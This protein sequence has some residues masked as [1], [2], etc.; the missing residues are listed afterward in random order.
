MKKTSKFITTALMLTV[1]LVILAL[2]VQEPSGAQTAPTIDI[3]SPADGSTVSGLV[4]LSADVNDSS[5]GVDR[6]YFRF[7]EDPYNEDWA[8]EDIGVKASYAVDWVSS[9]YQ[10]S[11]TAPVTG[12]LQAVALDNG[13]WVD[14]DEISLT[15]DNQRQFTIDSIE[16]TP[17]RAPYG[18]YWDTYKIDVTFTKM[19]PG[20]EIKGFGASVDIIGQ[21]PFL[22]DDFEFTPASAETPAKATVFMYL[23]EAANDTGEHTLYLRYYEGLP[24]QPSGWDSYSAFVS[25]GFTASPFVE[26]QAP[27]VNFTSPESE[28]VYTN[29]PVKFIAEATD[30]DDD[31]LYVDFYV[32][33]WAPENRVLRDSEPPYEYTWDTTDVGNNTEE[34][35]WVDATDSLGNQASDWGRED[36]RTVLYDSGAPIVTIQPIGE[37]AQPGTYETVFSVDDQEWNLLDYAEYKVDKM[38]EGGQGTEVVSWTEVTIDPENAYDVPLA[39]PNLAAGTYTLYMKATDKAGNVTDPVAFQEFKVHKPYEW[40]SYDEYNGHSYASVYEP[41]G[42]G[43]PSSEAEQAAISE[44]EVYGETAHL[45]TINSKAEQEWLAT[46]FAADHEMWI[47]LSKS[48][49]WGWL[50]GE[51]LTYTNWART[52][53]QAGD[54]LATMNP[55]VFSGKWTGRTEADP[56]LLP[57]LVEFKVAPYGIEFGPDYNATLTARPWVKWNEPISGVEATLERRTPTGAWAPVAF[58]LRYEASTNTSVMT[59]AKRLRP[60]TA[61][62]VSFTAEDADGVIGHE[63]WEFGTRG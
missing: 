19:L 9:Q 50:S 21:P 60:A 15:L 49:G 54:T 45:V 35:F 16:R 27:I 14:S 33:G 42:A 48:S 7:E 41:G 6:V 51:P 40:G 1:L 17:N 25:K 3:T 55:S 32:G 37:A 61:Y 24:D 5:G 44:G 57:A 12:T 30:P 47:G 29:G 34:F 13:N 20:L 11:S 8:G 56:V 53:P 23:G 38:D 2:L 62:K 28:Y 43:M 4:H 63:E 52:E 46:T 31:L 59:P 10:A 36:Y 39:L 26:A 18:D 58:K 22:S